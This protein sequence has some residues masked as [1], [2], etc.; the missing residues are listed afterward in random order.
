MNN[1]NDLRRLHGKQNKDGDPDP[2]TLLFH[3]ASGSLIWI[4][5]THPEIL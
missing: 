5:Q 4:A 1:G 3:S 2:S